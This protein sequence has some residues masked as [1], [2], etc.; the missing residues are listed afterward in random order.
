MDRANLKQQWP[1]IAWIRGAHFI[2][3]VGTKKVSLKYIFPCRDLKNK[4]KK[5]QRRRVLGVGILYLRF[6]VDQSCPMCNYV[7]LGYVSCRAIWKHV[8]FSILSRWSNRPTDYAEILCWFNHQIKVTGCGTGWFLISPLKWVSVVMCMPWWQCRMQ[9]VRKLVPFLNPLEPRWYGCIP[10]IFPIA[11]PIYFLTYSIKVYT[12]L[13]P[14]KR[15][16]GGITPSNPHCILRGP[17]SQKRERN[18]HVEV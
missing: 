8:I 7:S 11:V 12:W 9:A 5:N 16:I 10:I 4:N 3:D 18:Y 14:I 1:R 6:E 13:S 17:G 2:S 15:P